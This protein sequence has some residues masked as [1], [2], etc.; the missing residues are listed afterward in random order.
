MS[1][2][3]N[4]IGRKKKQRGELVLYELGIEPLPSFFFKG[5]RALHSP[6]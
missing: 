3:G 5:M 4:G 6:V 2:L 1:F